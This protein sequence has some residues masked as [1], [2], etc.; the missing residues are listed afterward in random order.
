MALRHQRAP[1]TPRRVA[2]LRPGSVQRAPSVTKQARA[3]SVMPV[4]AAS[5]MPALAAR[6][7]DA[8]A[9]RSSRPSTEE[10]WSANPR[11]VAGSD[12]SQQAV[13]VRQAGQ[14]ERD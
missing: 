8:R 13:F 3:V 12:F 7:A 4:L 5:V 9:V 2:A 1:P 14:G 6:P 11:R 10:L